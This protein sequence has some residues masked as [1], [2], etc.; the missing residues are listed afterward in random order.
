MPFKDNRL[1]IEALE[2]TGDL[3]RIKQ[4]VDW[5][6]EVGAIVRRTNEKLG[7]AILC[8]NIK[9]YPGQGIFGAPVASFRRMAIALGIPPDTPRQKL[10]I[11]IMIGLKSLLSRFWLKMHLVKKLLR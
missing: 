11:H 4:E 10:W 5:D 1:Y 3:V 8:E 6:C 7:P 9:D 2:K